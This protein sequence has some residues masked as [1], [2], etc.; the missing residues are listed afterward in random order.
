MQIRRPR[1]DR[2]DSRAQLGRDAV[3]RAVTGP[4]LRKERPEHPDRARL[5]LNGVAPH[6][7]P[8]R[9]LLLRGEAVLGPRLRWTQGDS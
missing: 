7:R 9:A 6:S 3:D 1:P 8:T 4:Q 5:R 2:R